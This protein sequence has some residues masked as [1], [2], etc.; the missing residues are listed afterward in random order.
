MRPPKTNDVYTT[1][2]VLR[3]QLATEEEARKKCK[4]ELAR[5]R[6]AIA[7]LVYQASEPAKL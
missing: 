2:H 1:N 5:A 6:A 4:A 7:D 3:V